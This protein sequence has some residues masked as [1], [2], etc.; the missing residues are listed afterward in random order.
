MRKQQKT[1]VSGW[2]HQWEHVNI[3]CWIINFMIFSGFINCGWRSWSWQR[4]CYSLQMFRT[5]SFF[6]QQYD[7]SNVVIMIVNWCKMTCW[8]NKIVLHLF[9][10]AIL[11]LICSLFNIINNNNNNTFYF[12]APFMT[13]TFALYFRKQSRVK[14]S[15]SC[16]AKSMIKTRHQVGD[17]GR[18]R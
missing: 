17:P 2:W 11:L 12:K 4:L 6:P 9:H 3:S 18:R 5:I 16:V 1:S 13:P 15:N 10:Y 7:W 8:Y 14:N